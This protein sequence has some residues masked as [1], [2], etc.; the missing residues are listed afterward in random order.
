[1]LNANSKL[2][3]KESKVCWNAWPWARNTETVLEPD[4]QTQ[5]RELRLNNPL[6]AAELF[7][8]HM[9][10]RS[11]GEK[12]HNLWFK[13]TLT[14]QNKESG[15]GKFGGFGSL[16]SIKHTISP[17]AGTFLRH[18]SATCLKHVVFLTRKPFM[19]C[20]S[21]LPELNVKIKFD[22]ELAFCSQPQ[23]MKIPSSWFPLF[24][25]PLT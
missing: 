15:S 17:R 23:S 9:L 24:L 7:S 5:P 8:A 10:W 2:P 19:Y 16:I 21:L 25:K 3:R 13:S 1:M 18:I 4:I 11:S 12:L 20:E 14:T 6:S 22:L